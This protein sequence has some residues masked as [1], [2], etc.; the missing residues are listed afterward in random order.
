M[1]PAIEIHGV[2]VVL[3]GKKILRDVS[4][5]IPRGQI[6]GLL[7]PSGA[8][9]TTLIRTILGLQEPSK[10]R[11]HVLGVPA[12]TE[13]LRSEIGYV[14]QAP[15]VYPDLTVA[16]NLGYFAA[17]RNADKQEVAAILREVEL[18]DQADQLVSTVSGGQKARVSLAVALLG[19]PQIL[20]LD[21]P[22]VGLDPVLR[23]KLWAKFAD[24]A[25]Q[26]VTLL[27][28]SHV[29]DEAEKCDRLL[30][31]RDG[32]LLAADT[33]E[34]ILKSTKTKTMEAAFLKLATGDA[35]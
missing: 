26:G 19:S 8:G 32:R 23:Q 31:I 9:K 10:G 24:L 4:A 17:L 14:T 28:S 13:R 22:T 29:M 34:H 5:T 27:I 12:G 16:E 11:I 2:S 25:K 7:G 1:E 3:G 6:I 35:T 15:S 21:E 18:T 33:R 20:L 30:F